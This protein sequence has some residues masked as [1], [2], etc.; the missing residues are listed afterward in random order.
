[1]GEEK[2]KREMILFPIILYLGLEGADYRLGLMK[3]GSEALNGTRR[4]PSGTGKQ[5]SK[6]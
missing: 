1:M 5:L 3:S 6:A 4:W 2:Q